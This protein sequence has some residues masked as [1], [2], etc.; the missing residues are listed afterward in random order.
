MAFQGKLTEQLTLIQEAQLK[1]SGEYIVMM[2]MM[3]MTE[4]EKRGW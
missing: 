2:M 1:K 3:M 4:R